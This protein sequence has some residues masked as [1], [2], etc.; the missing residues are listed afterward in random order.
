MI[1]N[2][3]ADNEREE[4]FLIADIGSAMTTVALFD[5][6]A[7]SYRL[8]AR[9]AAPTTAVAPW[10]DVSRGVR[11]AIR[12]ISEV[13]G[14]R[15]LNERG[16]LVQPMQRTGGGVDHFGV[17]ASA[18]HPL[19]TVLVGLFDRVSMASA[20]K[21]LRS[22]YYEELDSLSL[23][24]GRSE[25]EQLAAF[26]ASD[27]DLVFITGGTDGGAEKRLL[28]LVELV[29]LGFKVN[30]QKKRTH[31][32][33]AGNVNLRETV[34]EAIGESATIQVVNNVRP[35][36]EMEQLGDAVRA[37]SELY[38]DLKI[39]ALPGV[40]DLVD[41]NRGPMRPTVHALAAVGEYFAAL[42]NQP[43]LAVD[44]GSSSVSFVAAYP[45]D[46][47]LSV[48]TD[49]GMGLPLRH[50]L[51][52]VSPEAV[53]R[54]L[55]AELSE[56]E[57]ADFLFN[58]SLYPT[59]IP[60]TELD[61]QLEQ[62]AAREVIRCALM[63]TAVDWGWPV[64]EDNIEMP[65]F[66][67]LLAR[68]S[69]LANSPRAGQVMLLLLDALQPTGIFSIVL[70]AY[71]VLPAL[72]A[73]HAQKPTAVVQTL[74]AGVLSDL[75]WVIAPRGKG[76]P[77]KTALT[78]VV[79]LDGNAAFEGEVEYGKIETFPIQPGQKAQ[80]TVTPTNQFD[81]GFGYGKGQK[82]T[83]TGGIVGSL[84]VDA[85]GRPLQLPHDQADRRSLVRKWLWDM[86][87]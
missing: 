7:G 31:V 81:I 23:G 85:R 14:R 47:K 72:G 56:T 63:R 75:G 50:L 36:L 16:N 60:V 13:T 32:V 73:L 62:A 83:L 9:A 30:P 82:L 70:D 53:Q 80:V 27:P 65:P 15:L 37:A 46:V 45:D 55:P 6:V 21:A 41:W 4:S 68:G 34:R 54:W 79:E 22:V 52:H 87:G 64:H 48:H 28:Q 42:Q 67:L 3:P 26:L 77:G 51:E 66:G 40:A 35:S 61:L 17:I 20:R 10:Y 38:E 19:R 12:R 8:L 33:Y 74:E 71:G 58:R 49:L 1:S 39:K 2:I 44:L 25:R 11:Q 24:D 5:T 86:G 57:T 43:I 29:S 76:Q 59:T 78:V 84:V 69:I 18:A